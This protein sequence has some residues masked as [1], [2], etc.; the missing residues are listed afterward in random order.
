MRYGAVDTTQ[1]LR[2]QRSIPKT[3]R[4]LEFGNHV[5]FRYNLI[6]ILFLT[7]AANSQENKSLSEALN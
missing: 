7:N 4:N 5:N 6:K 3:Q 1:D 2:L